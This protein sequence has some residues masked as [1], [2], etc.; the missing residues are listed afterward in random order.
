M[1]D[2]TKSMQRSYEYYIVDP[3]TWKDSKKINCVL[4]SSINR[5]SSAE[6]LG[7]AT[8]KTTELLGEVYIRAYL[9]TIQNGLR[10]R[11]VLGTFLA[12][13]P[14]RPFDGRLST[15]DIDAYTPLMELKEN[16]PPIGYYVP[17][18][19]NVMD[20]GYRLIRDHCRAPVV[21]ASCVT[22][23]FSDFVSD[24]DDTW[25]SYTSDLIANAKY[26]IDL[27]ENGRILFAPKQDI[28]AMRPIWTYND[29]NS[30]ILYPDVTVSYDIYNVPNIVE[31]VYSN[32]GQYYYSKVVNDDP[33]SPTSIQSRGREICKRVINPEL[34]GYITEDRIDEY[35][36]QLLRELSSVV[37]TI[38]YSHAY[39]PVRLGDCVM[40]NYTRADLSGIK[41]VVTSQTIECNT[42]CRVNETASFVNKLWKG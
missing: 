10:E 17:K 27:D 20:M 29:D 3:G 33:S 37:H 26:K 25:L 14:T 32:G 30:S 21:P 23:V 15:T 22:K 4:S 18:D 7:S 9:V 34:T 1:P 24:T 13:T 8:F 28:A 12:Q 42:E 16:P 31:V 5:D 36:R 11:H 35:A 6:T 38:S 41:A 2:W 19:E 40:L 39:C